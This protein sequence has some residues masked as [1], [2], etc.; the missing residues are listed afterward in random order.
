MIGDYYVFWRI[1][2]ESCLFIPSPYVGD[3]HR[4]SCVPYVHGRGVKI[5]N[6]E[7]MR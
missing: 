7:Q 1:Q 6:F 4:F 5:L 3:L 2:R